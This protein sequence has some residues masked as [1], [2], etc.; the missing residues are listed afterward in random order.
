MTSELYDSKIDLE[1]SL[2]KPKCFIIA[3]ITHWIIAETIEEVKTFMLNMIDIEPED[4]EKYETL[5][6]K[7]Q[8]LGAYNFNGD[9]YK[10]SMREEFGRQIKKHKIPFELACSEY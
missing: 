1:N 7:V 2:K 8:Q 10:C 6:I 3:N 5:E 9:D 4:F